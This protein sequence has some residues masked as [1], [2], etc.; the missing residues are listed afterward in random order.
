MKK[1]QQQKQ[2]ANSQIPLKTP[3]SYTNRNG[4]LITKNK[5][6]VS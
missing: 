3:D 4:L 2:K 5:H 6:I 1:K